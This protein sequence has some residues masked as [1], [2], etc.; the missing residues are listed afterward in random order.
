VERN[1]AAPSDALQAV[2]S[3]QEFF[4]QSLGAALASN[5]VTVDG[6]TSHY[7]VQLLTLF[8]RADACH[9]VADSGP[10]HRPL[11]LILA[12]AVQAASREE[13]AYMLQRLG[14]VSLFNAGFFAEALHERAVGLDY[15]CNMGGGAYRML[16]TGAHTSLRARALAQ[17]FAELA[18]KFLDLV[19]VLNEV[20][21]SARGSTDQDVLR[22]Y[23]NWLRTGSRRA[24]RLLRQAGIQPVSHPLPEYR[25]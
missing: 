4:E 14:D 8:A 19:D 5:R 7:V 17:V 24:G 2:T 23:E 6:D 16:A 12:D 1:S 11:A 15:Y 20:R 10:G 25:H 18:A 3:L 22:L 9:D 13:R 21:E